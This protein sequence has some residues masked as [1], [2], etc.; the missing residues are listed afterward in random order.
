MSSSMILLGSSKFE[1][2]GL[3]LKNDIKSIN[4]LL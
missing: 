2:K 3:D 4:D 1:E